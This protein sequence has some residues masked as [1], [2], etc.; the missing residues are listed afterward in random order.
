MYTRRVRGSSG[1]V[2]VLAA[3]LIVLGGG[4]DAGAATLKA[5]YQLQGDRVSEVVGAPELTNLGAGNR[6]ALETVDGIARQVLAFPKGNG[7]SLATAGLVD[8][9]SNSVAML[10]RLADV[11]GY[12]R[13]LDFT[14]GTS[15]NGLYNLNGRVVIYGGAAA[16]QGIVFGD[17]YA[18]VVLANGV[19]RDGSRETVVYVNGVE[20]AAAKTPQGFDL[21][22]GVLRFFE[23]NTSGPATGEESAGAVACIL[24]YDGALAA[25]E[26][27]QVAADPTLCPAPRSVQ[28][29]P[30][31]EA[32]EKA[33]GEKLGAVDRRG[34]GPERELPDRHRGLCGKRSSGC[35]LDS[36]PAGSGAGQAIGRGQV[37]CPGRLEQARRSA[38]V[39]AS[40]QGSAQGREAEGQGLSGDRGAGRKELQG[41]AGREN[42]GPC[43]RCLQVRYLR[44]N[45]EPGPA[46]L[47]CGGPGSD[48]IG[49][50]P[51][52]CEVRR[53]ANTHQRDLPP[54]GAS[55]PRTL[56]LWRCPR[57]GRI[58]SRIRQD[59]GCPRFG[60][61]VS[62]GCERI[63]S[64]VRGEEDRVAR[65]D[66]QRG[67]GSI[68]LRG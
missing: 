14:N 36:R 34:Y 10:F 53:W 37:F 44:R 59:Q 61:A 16:S 58:G 23:D 42:R 18:Q 33:G 63:W 7:L 6:F 50:L 30:K 40:S 24:V 25:S 8:P 66:R 3:A 28:G 65:S 27:G 56:L 68:A 48:R 60:H 17:S 49:L 54:G 67:S 45:H 21:G 52:A 12:R 62:R 41:A 11:S 19:V 20:V 22:S 57:D 55:S 9:G 15:D 38:A 26:V 29:K 46:D 35:A 43:A 32:V 47:P 64:K 2:G 13:I 1:L 51:L 39:R 5:N 31:A 4:D